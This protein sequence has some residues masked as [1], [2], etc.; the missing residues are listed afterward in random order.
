MQH[1]SLGHDEVDAVEGEYVVE[2]LEGRLVL[3]DFLGV[4]D[5]NDF[6]I[7]G[8]HYL[9]WFVVYS[10]VVHFRIA[11]VYAC[12]STFRNRKYLDNIV[13]GRY[14]YLIIEFVP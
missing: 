6:S 4:V 13:V 3:F 10:D 1:P 12:S 8:N 5:Y 9:P 7:A 11:A 2:V 14:D